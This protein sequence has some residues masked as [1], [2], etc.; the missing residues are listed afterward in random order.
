MNQTEFADPAGGGGVV[1]VVGSIMND[2]IQRNNIRMHFPQD[3]AKASKAA[4]MHTS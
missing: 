3:K 1:V 4:H 2:V